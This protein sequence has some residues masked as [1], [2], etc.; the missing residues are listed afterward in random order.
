MIT[1]ELFVQMINIAER[2][3]DETDRWDDFGIEI[4]DMAICNIPWEMF[5]NWVDSHFDL[6]GKDWINWYLFERLS[7]NTNEVLPCYHEDG[8]E[9]FVNTPEDLWELVKDCRHKPCLDSPCTFNGI[10][11]CTGL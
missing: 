4:Y 6:N 5:R 3:S 2:F 9:F 8:T 11:P 10:G 1:K 7:F